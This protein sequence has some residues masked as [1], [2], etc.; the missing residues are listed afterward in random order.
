MDKK[1]SL[2]ELIQNAGVEPIPAREPCLPAPEASTSTVSKE[3]DQQARTILEN[4]R[5]T[6]PA[7]KP[8]LKRL[9]TSTS[10]EKDKPQDADA[11][12]WVFSHEEL[13]QALSAV[14]R[15]PST[16][17]ELVRAFVNRGVNVN[18]IDPCDNKKKGKPAQPPRRS[19]VLQQ[20]ASLRR[21]HCVAILASAGADQRTLSEA[22]K[23]ALT[24]KDKACVETLLRHGAD[25]NNFPT[26]LA[27]TVK[28]KDI[29]L[30]RILLRAPTPLRTTIVS[31]CLLVAV[32]AS[33]GPLAALL[34][35]HG[36]D[37]N[38]DAARALNEAIGMQDY[39][40][41]LTLVAG[42][43]PLSPQ[44]LQCLLDT[45]MRLPTPAAT[46]L[47][48]QL[49]FCC[50][51]PPTSIGLA[52]L[53]VCTARRDDVGGTRMML[54][55]GVRPVGEERRGDVKVEEAI[56]KGAAMHIERVDDVVS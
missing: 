22:L 49:L 16:S 34:L 8:V 52:D 32:Q 9:F 21:H 2:Q 1:V 54:S 43:T 28:A 47:Y 27:S 53:L 12:Q 29:D 44:T 20:A 11:T 30:A 25:V 46:L 40:L 48:L 33:S 17:P 42:P 51:L 37:P 50:G 10:K 38:F 15:T 19:T 6:N 41:A 35:S 26:A 39:K 4:R 56:G 45:V 13:D 36:A 14:L 23:S 5:R 55:Y 3:D 18:I 31:S 7:Q 24:N